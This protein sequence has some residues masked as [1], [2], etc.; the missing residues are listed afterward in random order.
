MLHHPDKLIVLMPMYE[1]IEYRRTLIAL[2]DALVVH[3]APD[4]Q[5]L[6]HLRPMQKLG[7]RSYVACFA[8]IAADLAAGYALALPEPERF[9][10]DLEAL[11]RQYGSA[12]DHAAIERAAHAIAER[13]RY[14]VRNVLEG[15]IHHQVGRMI[16]VARER[17][18]KT[19]RNERDGVNCQRGVPT[20]RSEQ[21]WHSL[22]S[23]WCDVRTSQRG[24]AA[25]ERWAQHNRPDM[26]A[27]LARGFRE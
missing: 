4:G 15:D 26:R 21:L 6:L 9:F 20:P 3:I 5:F 12:K 14:Q 24:K 10:A 1:A 13:T 27:R 8:G 16:I 11:A 18:T 25:W 7:P 19:D 2:D 22:R 17:R 23:E